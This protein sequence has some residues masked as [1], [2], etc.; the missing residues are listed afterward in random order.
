M[1]KDR[2]SVLWDAV[3]NNERENI[4]ASDLLL[5]AGLTQQQFQ[6]CFSAITKRNTIV[7]NRKPSEIYTNQ[8]NKDLLKA[9]NAN[10]DIQFILDAFSCVVYIISY[11]SKAERE[12]G[13]LL[14]Q[15]KNEAFEGNLNAQEA[16]KKVGTAYLHHREVS[17]QEAVYRVTGMHLKE[18]SRKVEFIP[19]GENP[20]RMSIPLKE[21]Q[22][23]LY[24]N[25]RD[26]PLHNDESGNK[27]DN[28]DIWMTSSVDRY[29]G[30]PH[31]DLFEKMC[32]ANFCSEYA[33]LYESQL[34]KKI[35]KETT[36][37]LENDMGYIRKRTKSKSA[38]IRYPRFSLETAREKH[39]QSILQL[40]LPYRDDLQLKPK[41][42]HTYENFYETGRVRYPGDKIILSVKEI[43]D[44]NMSK[45]I[46]DGQNLEDA[47]RVFEEQGPQED[48]W[49]ELCPETELDRQECIKEGKLAS[50]EEEE[51]ADQSIPDLNRNRNRSSR[52]TNLLLS[53]FPKNDIVPLLQ[54]LNIK[55]KQVF[56]KVRDWC[57]KKKNGQHPDPFHVFITGG[58]GTGKSHVI[59][60]IFYEATRL[61][62]QICDN[63]DDQ[64]VL[65]TAP[66]GTAA[67][68]INGLTIHSALGIFKSL[69]FDHALLSEDKLNSLRSKLE[70]LQIL[71]I[72]EIS[73]V[74]KRLLFFYS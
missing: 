24:R 21:V 49:C 14:Q 34:P 71:I 64:T 28:S 55:Q 69:S 51:N 45:Y 11:I 50:V 62:A 30:R 67:F 37:K 44:I 27:H 17:A 47:E 46:K 72:D 56:Y 38:I 73:M 1:A 59:K 31:F 16:M 3:K 23:K 29:K 68:N 12:I 35:N 58:A 39:F 33:V 18:C 22:K 6:E 26:S 53:N 48:A 5:K 4:S 66:A 52:T 70:N 25:T 74:N 20:C 8:Y 32:L 43:V 54:T 10:M 40:F 13:I 61:M 60:C 7:L 63:P 36:F 41:Q 19:V 42:F 57:I 9:W 65:L 15:T 2:L